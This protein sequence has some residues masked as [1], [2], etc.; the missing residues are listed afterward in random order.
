MTE[1][2]FSVFTPSYNRAKTLP[3]LYEALKRQTYRNF[4]WIIVDDGSADNTKETVE[5]FISDRPDFNITYKYQTNKGKHIATNVAAQIAKGE[6]FITIDSDDSVKDNALE[7]FINEWNKIPD[8]DRSNTREFRAAPVT[9]AAKQTVVL[10]RQ[11]DST[12][13][14]LT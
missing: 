4:E 2:T 3:R 10:C 11:N 5:K 8:K 12:V 6:F 7:T 13:P 1:Y 14:T 9:K